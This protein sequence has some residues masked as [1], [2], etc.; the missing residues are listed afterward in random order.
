[1]AVGAKGL[2]LTTCSATKLCDF[3]AKH[4]LSHSLSFPISKIRVSLQIKVLKKE[5]PLV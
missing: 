2:G 5:K 3:W 4:L 1:M